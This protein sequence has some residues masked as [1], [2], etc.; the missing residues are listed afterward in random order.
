MK[1]ELVKKPK[2]DLEH[3]QQ[4]YKNMHYKIKL[5]NKWSSHCKMLAQLYSYTEKKLN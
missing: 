1:R 3:R 5:C 4:K 2:Y